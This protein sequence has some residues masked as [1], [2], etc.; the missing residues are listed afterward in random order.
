MKGRN[1]E[2]KT[3]E[4]RKREKTGKTDNERGIKV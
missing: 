4:K 2:R 1:T 3:E